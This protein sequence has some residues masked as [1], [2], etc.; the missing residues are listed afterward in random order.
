MA[1]MPWAV[2]VDLTRVTELRAG[3]V[4]RLGALVERVRAEFVGLHFVTNGGAVDGVLTVA[5]A[6]KR[7][8][9]HHSIAAAQQAL[10]RDPGVTHG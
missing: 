3:A 1:T 9:V 10:T 2:V 7:I 5:P 6:G 8:I 4:P